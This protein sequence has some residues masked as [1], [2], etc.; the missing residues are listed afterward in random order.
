[1]ARRLVERTFDPKKPLVARRDFVAAGRPYKIGDAFDW[2][3]LAV[4][5]R[6][7]LQMFEANLV[8]HTDEAQAAPPAPPVVEAPTNEDLNI[9]SLAA[10]QEI[11]RKEGAPIRT[12]KVLQREAIIAHREA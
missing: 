10:L 1:M 7:V 4:A 9:D 3:R 2:K 11:A 12:T 6:R 5:Q 8:G